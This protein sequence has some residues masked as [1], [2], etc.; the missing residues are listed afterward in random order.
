MTVLE[1]HSFRGMKNVIEGTIIYAQSIRQYAFIKIITFIDIS[2][3]SL[4]ALMEKNSEILPIL[5]A[6]PLFFLAAFGG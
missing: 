5:T 4:K 3:T 6:I 1:F 2:L